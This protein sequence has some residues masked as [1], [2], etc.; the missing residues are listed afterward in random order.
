MSAP[1]PLPTPIREV[2]VSPDQPI[3]GS[4]LLADTPW[5]ARGLVSHW[6]ATRA[7]RYPDPRSFLSYVQS[8][9]AGKPTSAFIAEAEHQGRLFY[10][11]SFDGFNFIQLDTT[12]EAVFSKLLNLCEEECPP[13]LYV[14]STPVDTALPGFR[15]DNSLEMPGV[16]PLVSIWLG[17]RSRV[18]AHFD[19][20]RNLA[21][22][23]AGKRR[24]TVFPPEQVENL[25]IGP[26]DLTPA[27]QPISLVDTLAPDLDR[28]PRFTTAWAVAQ[29][30]ELEPGDVVYLP[31]M[32]WHQVESLAPVNGLVNYWWSE[33]PAVYG[34]PMDA[35]NHALLALRQLP[36]A[37]RRAWKSLFD[38]Y[39][40]NED[41]DALDHI[42]EPARGR[43]ASLDSDSARRVRADLINRLKR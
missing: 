34:A 43:L 38:Q 18:A 16:D 28:F 31:G 29:S 9:S 35:F 39:V 36:G 32:W 21:C 7:A 5:V 24:F 4:L 42:P 15:T 40:F 3:D 17:N 13:T 27:G 8:F 26:W 33:I 20:P 10:N 6:P 1:L 2:D 23:I 25:Y 12:L 30:T 11:E 41:R 37:Q 14:G 22:C 19:Y